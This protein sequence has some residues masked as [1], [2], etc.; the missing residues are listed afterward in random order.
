MSI[1]FESFHPRILIVNHFDGL[2]NRIDIKTEELIE[3]IRKKASVE[4]LTREKVDEHI[5]NELRSEQIDKITE[6]RD[7]NLEFLANDFNLS[8]YTEKWSNIFV[9][10]TLNNDEKCDKI[11]EHIIKYDCAL[12]EIY[13]IPNG[14]ELWIIDWYNNTQNLSYL[15]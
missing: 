4:N 8:E 10:T 3:N 2:V 11:K 1:E 12:L 13:Y 14:L 6:I 15:M 7:L 5:L 9:D